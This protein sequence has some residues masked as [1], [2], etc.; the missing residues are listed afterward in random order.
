M[1]TESHEGLR[2]KT[3][4]RVGM[5]IPNPVARASF[6]YSRNKRQGRTGEQSEPLGKVGNHGQKAASRSPHTTCRPGLSRNY[7]AVFTEL[8]PPSTKPGILWISKLSI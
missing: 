8:S 4:Q 1:H 7:A 2:G 5:V 6:I 3:F